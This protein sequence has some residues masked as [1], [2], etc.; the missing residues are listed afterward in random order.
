MQIK[1][2]QFYHLCFIF[3][4]IFLFI[5]AGHGQSGSCRTIEIKDACASM[6]T[7]KKT[8]G[9]LFLKM[10]LNYKL[11]GNSSD[12]EN[13]ELKVTANNM[14]DYVIALPPS[15]MK[16]NCDNF[17][18]QTQYLFG[19]NDN[20][21][22][23]ISDPFFFVSKTMALSITFRSKEGISWKDSGNIITS[24]T[25]VRKT[26][27]PKM[28]TLA[29]SAFDSN[30]CSH[31]LSIAFDKMKDYTYEAMLYEGDTLIDGASSGGKQIRSEGVEISSSISVMNNVYEC[32]AQKKGNPYYFQIGVKA[33]RPACLESDVA[34]SQIVRVKDITCIGPTVKIWKMKGKNGEEIND[35]AIPY[36]LEIYAKGANGET[37]NALTLQ[38]LYDKAADSIRTDF[39]EGRGFKDNV[40][41]TVTVKP[42]NKADDDIYTIILEAT[43]EIDNRMLVSGSYILN[44]RATF[45][46]KAREEPA[47]TSSS[48]KKSI[49]P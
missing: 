16:L 29:V 24:I 42:A 49:A 17:S 23:E 30:D 25:Y 37:P 32:V 9:T 31:R 47:K 3:I 39:Y 2:R 41:R 26:E 14:Q 18:T 33:K 1:Y 45:G 44:I 28:P 46:E 27:K 10:K 43:D 19:F 5:H 20:T 34:Y 48:T 7:G 38:I 35:A 8:D 22:Q 21:N 4:G 15:S 6:E 12:A 11:K 40:L 36:I 13:C